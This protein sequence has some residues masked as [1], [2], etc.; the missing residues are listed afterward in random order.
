MT[1]RTFQHNLPAE[2]NGFVGRERDMAELRQ[3]LDV[4]RAVTLCGT[5][6]IGKSRLALHL[7]GAQVDEYDDGVWLVEFADL[8]QPD[9]V[10]R[11]VANAVGV[12]EEADRQLTDTLSAALRPR[13]LLLVLDNCEHLIE[14]CADICQ[15]LL[16]SCPRLR[17]VATSREPL[18]MPGE[19]IWRVPPLSLPPPNA[20]LTPEGLAR[21]EAVRL[22]AERAAA[23]RPGFAITAENAE[24]LARLCGA[25]DGVPLA[26]ELAAARVRVLSVEQI[27]A[28]LGDRFRLLGN[29]DRTA[30]PRQRTLRA[31]IDWSHELLTE[32][33]QVLLRRLAGF[34]G[35]SLEMAEQICTGD[36]LPAEDVLDLLTALVDKSLIVVDRE[37]AGEVR[38]RMLDTIRQYAAERLIEAGEAEDLRCRS[39]DYAVHTT[40]RISATG[41]ALIPAPWSV[42]VASFRRYDCDEDN[43]RSILGHC[44]EHGDAE[45]GLRIC[46][47]LRPCWVVRGY[48]TEGGAW[49]DSFLA[50]DAPEVP[51]AVRGAALVGRA[52][53]AYHEQDPAQVEERALE[54]LALC[55]AG[56]DD[57]G[58]GSALNVL[59]EVDLREGRLEHAAARIEEAFTTARACG[60]A[61]NEGYAL[62]TR[63]ALAALQG[64]LREAQ[65]SGEAALAV[66]RRIDQQW[67]A[68]RTLSGLGMLAQVRGDHAAARR[69]Y[70]E[71]LP[72]L[73]EV[74]ARPEIARCLAG[75]ARV[76]LDQG[77][78][79]LGRT[80]LTE[81]LMLSHSTGARLSVAR[82][83]EAFAAL[84]AREGDLR[85]TVQL[86]GAAAALREQVGSPPMSGARLEGLLAPARRQ[87]G[88]PLLMQLWAEGR[89]MPI[90][91]AVACAIETETA[92]A[93]PVPG[94]HTHAARSDL[95]RVTPT[96][97]TN[98]LTPREHEIT[99]LIARGLS[100]RGIADEL[101][102]SPA[103]AARHVAN[104]FIKL[105]FSSRAQVAA[106]A[107]ENG[108][109]YEASG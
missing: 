52:Q 34:A 14:A 30:P 71:A 67:G 17:I 58:V 45:E 20:P 37:V 39:R 10:V 13:R 78:L 55:R 56:G 73:R 28:R 61:W 100:N 50:L 109:G 103:T 26:I 41:M 90:D 33:E 47:A 59:A 108:H 75:I 24:P 7:A 85:R 96:A 80:H 60:D 98:T 81:S 62:G 87:L 106:W 21:H 12:V 101:V 63:G 16:A 82:G 74:E 51:P 22:F 36:D 18:R 42:T 89:E 83:L 31:T 15:T 72:I 40:E 95:S 8:Q 99:L 64:R 35:W 107:V 27:A 70:E 1:P 46:T 94:D 43:L 65:R 68:A 77:D 4:T 104:I 91:E 44:L 5:G 84:T 57:V 48:F 76:A 102:I 92:D 11:R 66:M 79:A 54:G 93:S 49:F 9:L 19:T 25:L 53:I 38:Y 32:P 2:P 6:G 88:P 69:Y 86:A 23:A 29:G 105:G 97:P 3:L